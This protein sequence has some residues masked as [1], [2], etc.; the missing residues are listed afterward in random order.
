MVRKQ[1]SFIV[2]AENIQNLHDVVGGSR[3][4]GF[5]NRIRRKMER[6]L[7]AVPPRTT[8]IMICDT[9]HEGCVFQSF[10]ALELPDL[11]LRD[12]CQDDE[13]DQGVGVFVS[14][15]KFYIVSIL[16]FV[17]KGCDVW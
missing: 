5:A 9:A 10:V 17:R 15:D 7:P 13:D 16:V 6:V 11:L 8:L 2:K 12:D 4:L 1:I 14:D 3:R